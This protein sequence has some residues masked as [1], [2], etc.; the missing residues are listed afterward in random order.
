MRGRAGLSSEFVAYVRD[1]YVAPTRLGQLRRTGRERAMDNFDAP[2]TQELYDG[3]KISVRG[4]QR[5]HIVVIVPRQANQVGCD[6]RVNAF[7]FG[8]AHIRPAYRVRTMPYLL[9]TRWTFGPF[10]PAL[11]RN[12]NGI[13]SGE[14]TVIQRRNPSSR[15]ALGGNA[16][17]TTL[18]PLLP[19]NSTTDYR[20]RVSHRR[21]FLDRWQRP[22]RQRLV[23]H[24]EPGKDLAHANQRCN[25]H[26]RNRADALKCQSSRNRRKRV[27]VNDIQRCSL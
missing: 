3:N 22:F 8:T 10:L 12:H 16:P 18:M 27:P 15:D 5:R 19:K 4:D 21:S 13:N 9:M 14:L 11:P 25:R 17:W 7:F 26:C 6:A 1:V 20:G 23:E 24:D 2:F